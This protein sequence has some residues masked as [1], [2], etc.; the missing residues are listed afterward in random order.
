MVFRGIFKGYNT[1]LYIATLTILVLYMIE[2]CPVVA[3]NRSQIFET[4]I[5]AWVVVRRAL[6][7]WLT[8]EGLTFW[9]N[10]N[11]LGIGNVNILRPNRLLLSLNLLLGRKV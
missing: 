2:F 6:K 10:L 4:L 7:I 9:S 3:I 8:V 1:R 5:K 11:I